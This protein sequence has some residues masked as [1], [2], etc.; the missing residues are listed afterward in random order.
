MFRAGDGDGGYVDLDDGGDGG[1][2]DGRDG[3]R[4]G[5]DETDET[6]ATDGGF[7]RSPP[8]GPA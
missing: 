8:V 7:R 4:N 1:V 5:D 6:V 2:D 3:N